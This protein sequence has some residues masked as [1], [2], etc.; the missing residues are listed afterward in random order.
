MIFHRC[1]FEKLTTL[2]LSFRNK[3]LRFVFLGILEKGEVPL[4]PRL[5]TFTTVPSRSLSNPEA[6]VEDGDGDSNTSANAECAPALVECITSMPPSPW[7]MRS[8]NS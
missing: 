4:P 8:S 5:A 7:E 2:E 1:C 6:E 3:L